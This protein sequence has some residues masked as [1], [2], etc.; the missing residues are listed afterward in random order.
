MAKGA[1]LVE[2]R[3][4][5]PERAEEFGKWYAEVHIPEVLALEGFVSG[6]LMKQLDGDGSFISY[7]EIEADDLTDVAK[8]LSAAARDGSIT[9]SDS[10]Q[11]DPPP[12][13]RF[14]EVTAEH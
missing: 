4:S 12:A 14:L 7:Y 8:R 9:M 5:S 3:A 1:L 10:M 13:M 11:M 6:R 2:S